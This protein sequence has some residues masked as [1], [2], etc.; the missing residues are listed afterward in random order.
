MLTL[1]SNPDTTIPKHGVL[2]YCAGHFA[3]II[4]KFGGKVVYTGKPKSVIYD[5]VL[6]RNSTTKND[7]ILMVGLLQQAITSPNRLSLIH[8]RV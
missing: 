2:R 3:G 4:E 5:E 8:N 1:C 7:R 6:K